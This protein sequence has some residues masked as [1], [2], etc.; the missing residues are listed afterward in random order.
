MTERLVLRDEFDGVVWRKSV[1]NGFPLAHPLD[2]T[3]HDGRWIE[4]LGAEV[5]SVVRVRVESVSERRILTRVVKRFDP[6]SDQWLRARDLVREECP[7]G[8]LVTER[9][10]R[11][12]LTIRLERDYETAWRRQVRRTFEKVPADPG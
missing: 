7:I 12:R 5:G 9:E 3:R 10:E 6:G 11:P 8:E 2:A 4:T 1:G